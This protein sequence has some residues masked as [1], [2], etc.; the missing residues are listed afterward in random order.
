MRPDNPNPTMNTSILCPDE[1]P[2]AG[3]L[4]QSGAR[5]LRGRDAAARRSAL[6]RFPLDDPFFDARGGCA[7]LHAD[8]LTEPDSPQRRSP[9]RRS[10]HD[11]QQRTA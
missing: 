7:V 1:P 6:R 11:R 2:I 8:P 9:A 5:I 3:P 10:A 4:S